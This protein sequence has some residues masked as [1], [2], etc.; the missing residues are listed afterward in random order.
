VL[1]SDFIINHTKPMKSGALL[2]AAS[3]LFAFG[4]LPQSQA[5]GPVVGNKPPPLQLEKVLQ[6]PAKA[7]VSWDRLKG[8]VVV[9]EFWATWC[10]PCIAAIPHL[11]ELADAFKDQP[12]QF[13]AITDEEESVVAPFLKRKPIHAWVGLDT[14]KSMQKDYAISGIPHTVV[15][16]RKGKVAAI[17]YPAVLTKQHLTDLVAGR[18]LNLAAPAPQGEGLR[19]G[20][21]PG[22]ADG[23]APLFQI[24]I[25]PSSAPTASSASSQGQMTLLGTSVLAIL[26]SCHS[27]NSTRIITNCSLPEGT[28]DYVVKLPA[29][30]DALARRWLQQAVETTFGLTAKRETREL[31]V[32]VLTAPDPDAPKLSPTVSTGGSSASSAPGSMRGVNVSVGSLTWTLESALKKPVLDETKLT[33]RYDLELKWEAKGLEPASTE[34]VTKAVREQLG[35]ELSAGKRPVEVLLVDKVAGEGDIEAIPAPVRLSTPKE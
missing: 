35:L 4:L 8:K 32:Y 24:S 26:S 34:A 22:G 29:K 17:T 15:I 2:F 30:K 16:D 5:A 9:L 21:F 20:R 31:D 14:D 28:Y 25:R 23:A 1:G 12:V 33:N 18:K 19:P 11:N 10:G 13:I 7:G 6:A 27:I 3:M